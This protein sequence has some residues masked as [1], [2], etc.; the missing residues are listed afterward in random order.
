[1][2]W[3]ASNAISKTKVANT[4]KKQKQW[5]ATANSVLQRTGDEASAIKIANAAVHRAGRYRRP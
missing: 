1:M 2:P 4:P 5:A 3:D